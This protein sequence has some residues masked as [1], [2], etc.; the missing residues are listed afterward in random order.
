MY[1]PLEI[2]NYYG[3]GLEDLYGKRYAGGIIYFVDI[4]HEYDFEG[5]VVSE[6]DLNEGTS[7]AWGCMATDLPIP[8]VSVSPPSGEG[9]ELGDGLNNSMSGCQLNSTANK[10]ALNYSFEGYSDWHLPSSL[11]LKE[12][13]DRLGTSSE[14]Q[15]NHTEYWSSTEFSSL[16]AWSY[17]IETSSFSTK[18]KSNS[19]IGVRAVRE[20]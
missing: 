9:A 2:Y 12:L 5:L 13:V 18:A 6:E 1:V 11:E 4:H 19:T 16:Y 10:I 7:A 3:Y 14:I 15:F 8:N 20:F 17:N